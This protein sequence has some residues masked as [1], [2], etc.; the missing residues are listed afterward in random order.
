MNFLRSF[1]LL[2]F[3]GPLSLV[4]EDSQLLKKFCK[5][6]YLAWFLHGPEVSST[7]TQSLLTLSLREGLKRKEMRRLCSNTEL[8]SK[9]EYGIELKNAKSVKIL[10]VSRSWSQRKIGRRGL[11]QANT[12]H[13]G[14]FLSRLLDFLIMVP[15]HSPLQPILPPINA[16]WATLV[17]QLQL[18]TCH[19]L[20]SFSVPRELQ[21]EEKDLIDYYIV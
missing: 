9:Q 13:S 4:I 2:M 19:H 12:R 15:S 14:N 10:E 5:I 11:S 1:H 16:V 20:L 3:H 8:N 6:L 7:N 21:F 17:S 18:S